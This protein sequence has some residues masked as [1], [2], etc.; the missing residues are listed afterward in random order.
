MR[1]GKRQNKSEEEE[2]TSKVKNW[3]EGRNEPEPRARART[4][5][6]TRARSGRE[7]T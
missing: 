6:R 5:A 2:G 4:R 3:H 1:R 7:R